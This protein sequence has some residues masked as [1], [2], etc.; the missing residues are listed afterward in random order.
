MIVLGAL[1]YYD[2]AEFTGWPPAKQSGQVG[3]LQQRGLLHYV[4]H[5][6]YSG[7]LV[8]LVGLVVYQ[9]DWKHLIFS[10]A[11]FGYIRIGIY[12][13]ERKLIRT[14]GDAYVH[15]RQRVPMLIPRFSKR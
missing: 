13:E 1:K 9:P 12:F 2:M 10:L 11:A 4:R 8:G 14:F 3:T 6:L 7:I 5:P 15:Y